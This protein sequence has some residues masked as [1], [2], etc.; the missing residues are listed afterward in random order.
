M[1][2]QHANST[3]LSPYEIIVHLLLYL[4]SR[5][6]LLEIAW[7]G[8]RWRM[9]LDMGRR[10]EVTG[11]LKF[12]IVWSKQ[13]IYLI[14]SHGIRDREFWWHTICEWLT[15]TCYLWVFMID[16]RDLYWKAYYI[17]WERILWWPTR[18]V[19]YL[20]MLTESLPRLL[21][22]ESQQLGPI[23]ISFHKHHSRQVV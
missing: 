4:L 22:V 19:Q 13:T 7:T 21:S 2:D 10:R 12:S 15:W 14:L 17:A 6:Q 20:V 9:Y 11:I 18:I 16:C 3:S 1:F 8:A 23:T 5:I